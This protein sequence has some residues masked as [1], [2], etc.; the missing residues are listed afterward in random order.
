MRY[1]HG[2]YIYVFNL[3]NLVL[4]IRM[5]TKKVYVIIVIAKILRSKDITLPM[6]AT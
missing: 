3:I 4:K 6:H 2:E 1:F 5:I